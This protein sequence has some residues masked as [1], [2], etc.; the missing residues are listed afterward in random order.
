LEQL[1]HEQNQGSKGSG[2]K[3]LRE[4]WLRKVAVDRDER[5]NTDSLHSDCD[6]PGFPGEW[7]AEL[8]HY[9]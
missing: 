3:W 1:L 5:G 9:I 8:N 6:V 4:V 2:E 7:L